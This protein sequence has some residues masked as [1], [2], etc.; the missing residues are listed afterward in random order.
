MR[1]ASGATAAVLVGALAA[2]GDA[3]AFTIDS[4]ITSGCH[5]DIT[6]DALR[7]ARRG[8][9][10]AGPLAPVTRDDRA[11]VRDLPYRVDDDMLFFGVTPLGLDVRLSR[12]VLLVLNPG[13]IAVPAPHLEGLPFAYVQYRFTVGVQLGAS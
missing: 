2:A 11:L 7:E 5:E 13:H 1:I 3:A 12:T 10:A 6:M 4:V 9:P 8:T